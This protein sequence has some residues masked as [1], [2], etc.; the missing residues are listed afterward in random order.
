MSKKLLIFLVAMCTTFLVVSCS[1]D[2]ST[3]ADLSEAPEVPDAVPVE[4]ENS[5]F[6]NNNVNGEEYAAFNEAGTIAESA[7]GQLMGATSLGQSFLMFTEGR[8]PTFEDGVWEWSFS[9]SEGGDE[10]SITTTAE[11]FSGGVEWTVFVSGNIDGESVTDF[12]FI[13]GFYSND[14]KIGNWQYFSPDNPSQPFLEYEW[15]TIDEQNYNFSTNFNDLDNGIQS[16]ISY[17]REGVDN[18][19][20]F[21]GFDASVDV[22]VYWN[23][24]SETGYIERDGERRCWDDSFEEVACS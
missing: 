24:D 6:T 18:T 16:S 22:I 2:S 14:N 19:L 3:D 8:E 10:F 13:Q 7:N 17:V 1:D 23:L 12:P 21:T 11:E 15:E 9:F 4:I 5:L 20:E